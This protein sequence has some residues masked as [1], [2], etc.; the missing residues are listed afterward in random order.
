MLL[1]LCP[2]SEV[3]EPLLKAR[4]NSN[5]SEEK[6]GMA[7]LHF[8]ILSEH[9]ASVA[10]LIAYSADIT[11]KDKRGRDATA[12]ALEVEKM[13]EFQKSRFDAATLLDP[14]TFQ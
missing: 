10:Q 3:V 4:A 7:P 14:H 12:C 8:A 13:E 2:I 9:W 1:M 6:G 5:K 11:Q